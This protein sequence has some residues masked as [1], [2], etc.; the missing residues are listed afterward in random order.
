MDLDPEH[1]NCASHCTELTTCTQSEARI[2]T[3]ENLSCKNCNMNFKTANDLL[4]HT[5][6]HMPCKYCDTIC[7]DTETYA[8]HIRLYHSRARCGIC[9]E[10]STGVLILMEHLKKEHKQAYENNA[11]LVQ[12]T[13]RAKENTPPPRY[14][15][16]PPRAQ[17]KIQTTGN[18]VLNRKA[19][20]AKKNTTKNNPV[21]KSSRLSEAGR[22]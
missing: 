19:R 22:S 15:N 17:A 16:H 4:I 5:N 20:K 12:K 10:V 2:E 1:E 3:K 18:D 8:S 9:N 7:K 6:Q 11:E 21:R 13:A 14:R